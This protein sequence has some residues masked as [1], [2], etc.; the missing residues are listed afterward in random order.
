[1]EWGNRAW[2]SRAIAHLGGESLYFRKYQSIE[3][4]LAFDDDP[5]WIRL[6]ADATGRPTRIQCKDPAAVANIGLAGLPLEKMGLYLDPGAGHVAG[7][8]CCATGNTARPRRS[9]KW[10]CPPERR[11]GSTRQLCPISAPPPAIT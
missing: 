10:A 4:N 11:A 2:R 3:Q 7:C 9:V 5:D 6:S 8:G 1:M